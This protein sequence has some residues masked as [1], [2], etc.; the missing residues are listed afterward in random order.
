MGGE[1]GESCSDRGGASGRR[2]SRGGNGGRDGGA[3][4]GRSGEESSRC[5]SIEAVEPDTSSVD[6]DRFIAYTVMPPHS[7]TTTPPH[8]HSGGMHPALILERNRPRTLPSLT[9][10]RAASSPV[11]SG[12]GPSSSS[13]RP[14]R[15]FPCPPLSSPRLGRRERVGRIANAAVAVAAV[16]GGPSLDIFRSTRSSNGSPDG[17]SSTQDT[18][19]SIAPRPCTPRAAPH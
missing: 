17:P 4:G 12:R 10:C 15:N 7:A 5:L 16:S 14:N 19:V 9:A 6:P 3:G 11:E 18:S 13:S 1:S 2:D 8:Q